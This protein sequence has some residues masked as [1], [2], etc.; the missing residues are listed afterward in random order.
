MLDKIG[1]K[2]NP[3]NFCVANT[4]IDGSQC[5]IAWHVD[6]NKVSH[7]DE[8]FVTRLIKELEVHF[9]KLKVTGGKLHDYLGMRIKI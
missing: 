1:F 6:Y 5:T 2:I 7:V 3:Y 4:M 9:G 8:K